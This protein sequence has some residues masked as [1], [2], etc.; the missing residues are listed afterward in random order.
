M[1]YGGDYYP[2]QWDPAIWRE[3]IERMQE[4]GVTMV[5]VGVFA[6][7]RI[8][9]REGEFDW[10]WLD[11]VL[12]LLHAAGIGVDLAT[13]TASPP[14][15]ATTAYPEMLPRDHE[16]VVY[17]PGS[18]Q[19]YAPTSPDYRRLASD[20]VTTMA[21]RYA[22]HPAVQM[23]HVNNEYGC[24]L[25]YD[26]SDNAE[27]AFRGWLQKKY[28]DIG[29]LNAAWGTMFWSQSFGTFAEVPLPRRAP[30]IHNPAAELD[31]RRFTS[32]ALLELFVMERDI[33]RAAG[34]SQPVTTNFMGA[35]PAADYWRWAEEIDIISDDTYPDPN[36]PEAYLDSAFTRDL[37]RSL[38][39]GRPWLVMEQATEAANS[40]LT[41]APKA[42]GQ[43]EAL[44]L[45]SVGR[46]ADGIMFFQWRQSRR[47][48]EKFH[49]AMLPHTGTDTRVWREVVHLG[50]TLRALPPLPA[51]SSGAR[52]ALVFTWESWWASSSPDLP[53]VVDYEAHAR[54]WHGAAQQLHLPVDL[55]RGDEDLSGYDLVVAPS[56]FLVDDRTAASL[57]RYVEAG[58]HLIVT[59]FSDVVD[60]DCAFREGGFTVALGEVLG[61]ETL[62]FGAL[63]PAGGGHG[64]GLDGVTVGTPFGDLRGHTAAE[65]IRLRG[66]EVVGR[67]A[68]GREAGAP[69]LTRHSFGDGHAHYLA[70][71]PDAAAARAILESFS[72]ELD[73]APLLEGP[74]VPFVDASRRGDHVTIVNHGSADAAVSITGTDISTAQR[75]TRVLLQ[76]FE[77]AII[78]TE[79]EA[80]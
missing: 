3:D 62:E 57:R 30:Y 79:E 75:V 56:L 27:Q 2:E 18:R 44:S 70:T 59:A 15:W 54:A 22:R 55:V 14:P 12:D 16:G 77:W 7:A 42:P 50:Q 19:H 25:H 80:R 53:T 65:V 28:S 10:A 6:W 39:P 29:S 78:R 64:P 40:R 31:F 11:E 20:L 5:T 48:A 74:P 36:D 71:L 68:D 9:P 47:G 21:A 38:K 52:I 49:S 35:F 60:A 43:A 37:M 32:D 17:S 69:A 24:H 46:G 4:A 58:G 1:H 51:G 41:N 72:R 76:P 8:Q 67:F 23:W 45:Q 66:A 63:V 34:A 61:V 73:I 13:A 33:L 26:Y